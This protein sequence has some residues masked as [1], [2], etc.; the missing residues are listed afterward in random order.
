MHIEGYR[1][2]RSWAV[3][4]VDDVQSQ[5]LER[6]KE[7]IKSLQME[8]RSLKAKNTMASDALDSTNC[9]KESVQGEENVVEIHEDKNVISHQ[10]D[11][12]SGVSDNQEA[13]L[14]ENQTSDDIIRKP[15][16]VAQELLISSSSENGTAGN[17][18]NAPKQNGEPPPEES[19]V[20]IS[21][22]VG[23]KTDSE[24]MVSS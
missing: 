4:D 12:T 19:E 1:S 9:E 11:L 2:G 14:P 17:I 21:D 22:N 24:K 7:E 18:V 23:G 15:E 5:S 8:I 16:E 3:S 20:L 10:V 6:Y 13:Q